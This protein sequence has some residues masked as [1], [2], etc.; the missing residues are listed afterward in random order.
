MKIINV[1]ITTTQISPDEIFL[2]AEGEPSPILS[3]LNLTI[4]NVL[5][6]KK[7]PVL[8]IGTSGDELLRYC[9]LLERCELVYDPNYQG[10]L[11]S[12]VKAGLHVCKGTTFVLPE[13]LESVQTAIWEKFESAAFAL[14]HA[15][16]D[17]LC[18]VASGVPL[19]VTI[20]GARR[21][22]SLSAETTKWHETSEISRCELACPA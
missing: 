20:Q 16:Y 21:L 18:P 22:M 11:F 7:T 13:P 19:I 5:A 4:Q 10:D 12:S 17:I 14:A 6:L 9:H 8:V 3:R 1:I 15:K 2:T